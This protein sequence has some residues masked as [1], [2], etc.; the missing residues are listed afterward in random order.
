MLNKQKGDQ[1]EFYCKTY[2]ETFYPNN[3]TYLYR[4]VPDNILEKYKLPNRDEGLDI[5]MI[6]N[7]TEKLYGVQCKFRSNVDTCVQ[8]SNVSTFAG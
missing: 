6:D 1:F 4:D 7:F 3:K 5:L 2:L 8:W